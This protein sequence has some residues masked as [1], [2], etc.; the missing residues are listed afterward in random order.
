MKR[1]AQE[2][3]RETGPSSSREHDPHPQRGRD[4]RPRA[5]RRPCGR[6]SAATGTLGWS[7]SKAAALND[8]GQ[9]VGWAATG[10]KDSS[11]SS[12]GH[13]FLW[14][15]GK[16]TDLGTLG[17]ESSEAAAINELGQVVGWAQTEEKDRRGFTRG[18][19]FLW[20]NGKMTDLGTVRGWPS[21]WA[22][23]IN[24]HGQILGSVSV[25]T[26]SS[27]PTQSALWTLRSR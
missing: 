19:V 25:Y 10:A 24:E 26:G 18:H 6:C 22:D 7:S 12:P 2:E 5:A 1:H 13:A 17:G 3:G 8:R 15:N 27:A 20:E 23:A 11:G 21:S 4:E 16:V 9:V 14:E